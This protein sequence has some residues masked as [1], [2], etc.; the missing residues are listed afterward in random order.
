MR[1]LDSIIGSK[2]EMTKETLQSFLEDVSIELNCKHQD[3]ICVIKPTDDEFN[4]KCFILKATPELL[5]SI[6]KSLHRE[7]TVKEILGEEEKS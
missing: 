3:F 6:P 4:F 1:I 5:A 2:E 7:V